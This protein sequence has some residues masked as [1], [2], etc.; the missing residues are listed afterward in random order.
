M[1]L[2]LQE[3]SIITENDSDTLL[4]SSEVDEEAQIAAP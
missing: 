4:R 2:Y 3:D 1:Y